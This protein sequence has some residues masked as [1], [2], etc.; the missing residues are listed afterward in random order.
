MDQAAL[1]ALL[2]ALTPAARPTINSGLSLQ[3][4]T[5]ISALIQAI[6]NAQT[7]ASNI[8]DRD[9]RDQWNVLLAFMLLILQ[10]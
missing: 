9:T 8:A 3:L 10:N 6:A 1:N 2:S 5:G 7:A 4:D